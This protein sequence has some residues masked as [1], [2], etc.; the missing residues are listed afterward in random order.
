MR[1]I[2][3]GD[4]VTGTGNY[5]VVTNLIKRGNDGKLIAHVLEKNG[6]V[7]TILADN[8]YPIGKRMDLTKVFKTIDLIVDI[9]R[10][11]G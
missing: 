4:V 3:I 11:H 1:D 8:L 7:T 5:G 6:C 2:K 9:Y 10:K